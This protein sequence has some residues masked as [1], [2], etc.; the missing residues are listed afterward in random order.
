MLKSITDIERT[1][2]DQ[3]KAS[4]IKYLVGN[5]KDMK[6]KRLLIGQ[7][8]LTEATQFDNVFLREVSALTNQGVKEMF[9]ELIEMTEEAMQNSSSKGTKD[10][11]DE[12]KEEYD[13]KKKNTNRSG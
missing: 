3:A 6:L 1:S 9:E 12:F 7:D 4:T 8:I 5:K 2:K 10:E 11:E 13:N